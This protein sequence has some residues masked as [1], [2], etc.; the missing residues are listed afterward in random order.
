MMYMVLLMLS[1]S[2]KKV[3]LNLIHRCWWKRKWCCYSWFPS[4]LNANAL[5]HLYRDK[6]VLQTGIGSKEFDG[7]SQHRALH[8]SEPKRVLDQ[9]ALFQL[10]ISMSVQRFSAA[11]S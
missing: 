1:L 6:F 7:Q 8:S 9:R 3:Y 5:L 11:P 10:A 4:K 2:G